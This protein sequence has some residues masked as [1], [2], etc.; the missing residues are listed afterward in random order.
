MPEPGWTD[1][2]E[3]LCLPLLTW[4]SSTSLLAPLNED[5]ARRWVKL[6]LYLVIGAGF[7]EL[8]VDDGTALSAGG[9]PLREA[10][11]PAVRDERFRA[12]AIALI[13]DPRGSECGE[14]GDTISACC[15]GIPRPG[16]DDSEPALNG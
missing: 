6:L 10:G 2:D 3:K 16:E 1:D 11:I 7:G 13:P 5:L 8:D 12:W 4:S 9:P 15:I 14:C